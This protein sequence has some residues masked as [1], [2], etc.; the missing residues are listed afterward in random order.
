[1]LTLSFSFCSNLL[2]AGTLFTEVVDKMQMKNPLYGYKEN[3]IR[4]SHMSEQTTERNK[5]F[6]GLACFAYV[7]KSRL[8]AR[9]SWLFQ[10]DLFCS[11]HNLCSD[12]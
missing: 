8:E 9:S 6:M 3:A 1:M 4:L 7:L 2:K 10:L 12:V 5:C 11:N